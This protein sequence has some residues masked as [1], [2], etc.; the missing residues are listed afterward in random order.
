MKRF[1]SSLL[2]A[3]FIVTLLML[4]NL[5]SHTVS[6]QPESDSSLQIEGTGPVT[7]VFEAGLGDTGNVW[8]SV[9][10]AVSQGCARTVVYSRSGYG[11]DNT[12][13]GIRDAEHIVGELR[14]RLADSGLPAPYILVGHSLGGLY[15]QYFTRRYPMEVQGLVLVDSTHWD[16]LERLRFVVPGMYFMMK[17]ASF[18]LSNIARREFANIST[19]GAEVNALPR[20][21][22]VPTIVLSSTRAA[23]GET[24]TY[25]TLAAQLQN[26]IAAAFATRR[27][28]YVIDSGHYVQ[29]DQPQVVISAARELA[30]CD[31]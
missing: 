28:E 24:S 23:M 15:M 25:R 18:L 29:R 30:G 13:E 8:D 16:Q 14:Q 31:T 27:H 5:H 19:S 6:A 11:V 17:T 10:S 4:L 3:V 2:A 9:Q 20:T 1:A 21:E 26:E 7:V 22:H 12:P